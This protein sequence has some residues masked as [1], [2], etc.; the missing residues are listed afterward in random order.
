MYR[1]APP[2]PIACPRCNKPMPPTDPTSCACGTWLSTFAAEIVLTAAEREA[3]PIKRWWRR[4]EPCPQCGEQM[5]L[6]NVEPGLLQGCD[7]HGFFIDAD[8]VPHTSLARG[9]DHAAIAAKRDDD[10]AVEAD[11]RRRLEAEQGRDDAKRA[12]AASE[13]RLRLELARDPTAA[14]LDAE[15]ALADPEP[16][17]PR[18]EFEHVGVEPVLGL[19]ARIGTEPEVERARTA[20]LAAALERAP[21]ELVDAFAI[22]EVRVR[23]LEAD[24]AALV[25]AVRLLHEHVM[26][27]R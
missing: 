27:L 11:A 18:R 22:F 13:R 16:R 1:H 10:A 4:R 9:I 7:V 6:R 26:T 14:E 24:R 5:T 23:A 21:R 15:A 12:K 20:A 25:E 8:T 19:L 3:D 2:S 17:R